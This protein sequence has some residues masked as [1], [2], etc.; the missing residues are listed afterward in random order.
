MLIVII[1]WMYVVILMA[2]TEHS[3]IAGLMT[4]LLYG[5][6]PLGTVVYLLNTP[7]RRARKKL[8][9]QQAEKQELSAG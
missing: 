8:A 1:A 4:F 5:L 6:L 7:A 2:L 3:F 9:E